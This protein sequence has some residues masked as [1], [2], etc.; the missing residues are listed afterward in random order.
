MAV[1][2]EIKGK[3]VTFDLRVN[4]GEVQ[5]NVVKVDGKEVVGGDV[6]WIGRGGELNRFAG[7]NGG[8]GLELNSRG[9]IKKGVGF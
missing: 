8:G 9:E 7:V 5:L 4:S 2:V 6:L 1:T 3:Q